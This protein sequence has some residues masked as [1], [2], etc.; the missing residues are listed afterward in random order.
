MKRTY[1]WKRDLPDHRDHYFLTQP[2][3][4]PS[5]VDLRAQCPP[6]FDQGN[7]GSCTAN[8][9]GA[10][11]M[12]EEMKQKE[13]LIFQPS[14]LFIYY[15]ERAI[16]GTIKSDSGAAIRDGIKTI[17]KQ[18]VCPEIE[19]PY[20]IKK[21]KTKPSKKCYQD[22]TKEVLK[23][24]LSI[25]QD[26]NSLKSC[27]AQGYPF[28]FGFTVYQSFESQEVAKSGI[29][30]MPDNNDSPIG[31]H[32]VMA[33]GYDDNNQAFIVRNSWG[34]TWGQAGYFYLP[35]AYVTNQNL[36]DDFWSLHLTS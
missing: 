10:A 15:N 5:L 2:I 30:P 18:G 34:S 12:F 35:Y 8:A 31:G 1:G 28:V 29:V 13:T 7:L 14:R 17:N 16:E 6:V 23:E 36:A 25:N 9:L 33:V 20:N 19:W 4:L 32:A 21:F 22:A 11:Y 26:L 24:Y 3:S 27:I